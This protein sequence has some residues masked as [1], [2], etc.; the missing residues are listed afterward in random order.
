MKNHII[1]IFSLL[2]VI[3]FCNSNFA[4]VTDVDWGHGI[5][6][7]HEAGPDSPKIGTRWGLASL[8]DS[9]QI[10][11]KLEAS[12]DM[13]KG[14]WV[15]DIRSANKFYSKI[16]LIDKSGNRRFLK[17]DNAQA[18]G[19]DAEYG[20]W[21]K[22]PAT[23]NQ[24]MLVFQL[25]WEKMQL[26]KNAKSLVVNYAEFETP[27]QTRDIV[28]P[29]DN[30]NSHLETLEAS[31]KNVAGAER[32]LMTAEEIDNTPMQDL[33]ATI[34]K[35]WEEDI[36]KLAV[37]LD[38]PVSKL[39]EYSMVG[40]KKLQK[41]KKDQ[42]YAAEKARKKRAHQAIYDQEPDWLDIN[43]CP[44]GSLQ[45]CNNVGKQAYETN[46]MIGEPFHYGTIL[47][48]VWRSKDSIVR[49]YGGDVD[50]GIEPEIYRAKNAGYYYIV[51][52]K[53]GN[54]DIRSVTGVTVKN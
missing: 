15:G 43:N 18:V 6:P 20:V 31:I 27:K 51:K 40:M 47:G 36:Q 42:A 9:I 35:R 26:I 7:L 39:R 23:S 48:V 17:V 5:E 32:F 13:T 44:N 14:S 50:L 22:G 28:F 25:N 30:F 41:D 34:Q 4:Q 37:H 21:K 52:S 2:I 16:Y 38:M 33:P 1:K 46:P 49:I 11:L 8:K 12:T 10:T 29:L 19:P 3:S 54:L 24:Q 45:Q 53:R